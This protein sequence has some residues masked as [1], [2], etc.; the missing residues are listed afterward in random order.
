MERIDR[1]GSSSEHTPEQS[2]QPPPHTPPPPQMPQV[3][4]AEIAR[5]LFELRTNQRYFAALFAGIFAMLVGA[6]VWA[7]VAY[8]TKFEVGYLA[9]A[10]GA[11]VGFAVKKAGRGVTPVFGIMGAILAVLGIAIGKVLGVVAFVANAENMR[12]FEVLSMLDLAV[13]LEVLRQSFH[14]I[15]VLFYGLAIYW[16]FK[17]SFRHITHAKL[18][19]AM[20]A[21]MTIPAVPYRN[22]SLNIRFNPPAAWVQRNVPPSNELLAIYA[23]QEKEDGFTPSIVLATE[24]L[25]KGISVDEFVEQNIRELKKKPTGVKII[26]KTEEPAG[27]GTAA[28]LVYEHTKEKPVLKAQMIIYIA[29]TRATLLTCMT[30]RESFERFQPVF[31]EACRSLIANTGR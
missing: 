20:A 31:D 26:E 13:I 17:H 21:E 28:K 14:P 29:G 3:D 5:Q 30:S 23:A 9:I 18:R 10:V 8:L 27:Q 1:L 24:D 7:L 25:H 16:G 12:F 22:D 6:V 11:L 4:E 2:S 19:A 15:D